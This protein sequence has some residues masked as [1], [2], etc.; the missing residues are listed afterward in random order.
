MNRGSIYGATITT[1]VGG[2]A[3]DPVLLFDNYVG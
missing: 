3:A 1:A 2:S